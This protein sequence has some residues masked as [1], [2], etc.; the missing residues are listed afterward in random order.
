MKLEIEYPLRGSRKFY[1]GTW[2]L[3]EEEL[4]QMVPGEVVGDQPVFL[5]IP[6]D[7]IRIDGKV[8]HVISH[9]LRFKENSTRRVYGFVYKL[10]KGKYVPP[11]WI[12][13]AE[14]L[15]NPAYNDTLFLGGKHMKE[16]FT[17]WTKQNLVHLAEFLQNYDPVTWERLFSAYDEWKRGN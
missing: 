17:K 4:I 2:E 8:Y 6:G 14:Y 3:H 10:E 16:D 15:N 12:E 13:I 1:R 5:L 11:E 9:E 7:N